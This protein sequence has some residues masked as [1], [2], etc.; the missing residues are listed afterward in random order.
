M[1]KLYISCPTKGR[2]WD[3]ITKTF[4][5]MH[6][7]AEILF[8][9]ELE[10]IDMLGLGNLEADDLATLARRIDAMKEADYFIGLREFEWSDSA[11]WP[12]C[13]LEY[14]VASAYGVECRFAEMKDVA[15]DCPAVVDRYLEDIR[16][17]EVAA[18]QVKLDI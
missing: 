15:P 6:R 4:D 12:M 8:D 1:K 7:I 17:K 5:K 18:A 10:V 14:M 3:D 13:R 16:E 11:I 2:K 9:Q